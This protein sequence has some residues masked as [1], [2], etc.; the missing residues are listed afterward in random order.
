MPATVLAPRPR[1][2]K[3]VLVALLALSSPPVVAQQ[4][5]ST[6]ALDDEQT[7]LVRVT[8]GQFVRVRLKDGSRAGGPLITATPTAFTVGPSVAFGDR[9]SVL[10]LGA[11]DSLWVRVPSTRRGALSGAVLGG[12][13]GLGIGLTS[14]ALCPTEGPGDAKPCASG[15]IATAA[16]GA[17]LG[18]I[19]G[20]LVGSGRTHWQ[21][22]LP[23][24]ETRSESGL[25][26]ATL[27]ARPDSTTYDP[28]ALVLMRIPSS[29]QVRL[30]F[31][32][33][34]DLAGHLLRTGAGGASLDVTIGTPGDAPIPM[35]SLESIWE[36]GTAR[37]TGAT[38]GMI[39]GTAAGIAIATQSASCDPDNSCSAAI[40][41]DAGAGALLGFLLG[42]AVGDHLPKWHRR[43]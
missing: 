17:L 9:D 30:T 32:D 15:V 35:E 34:G 10:A 19:M 24:G 8:P 26:V 37:R 36:R 6:F 20:S 31:K 12:L 13:A 16:S 14:T 38:A 5:G 43:Y 21:R 33:R 25:A 11:M 7:A 41:V 28:R 27:I 39:L 42:G 22:L 4:L 29:A 18:G 23:R 3:L 2:A 40:L 1:F